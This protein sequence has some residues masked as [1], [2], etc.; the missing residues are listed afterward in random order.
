WRPPAHQIRC[1]G[2]HLRVAATSKI[3]SGP[4]MI[5]N[6]GTEDGNNNQ[7]DM[8]V[9]LWLQDAVGVA[10]LTYLLG[11]EAAEV[12]AIALGEREPSERQA[13][14]IGLLSNFRRA[15]PSNLGEAANTQAPRWW[16][17]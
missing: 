1:V 10:V 9:V 11:C 12:E 2:P 16:L 7:L 4:E 5:D 14:I 8:S 13:E 15:L 17:T 6:D 3:E